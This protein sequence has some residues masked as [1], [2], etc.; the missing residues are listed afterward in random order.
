MYETESWLASPSSAGCAGKD[1]HK[2]ERGVGPPLVLSV[3]D[4]ERPVRVGQPLALQKE[5]EPL[6]LSSPGMW[7]GFKLHSAFMHCPLN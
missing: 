4:H 3:D 6:E 5:L 2:L 1:W 7:T